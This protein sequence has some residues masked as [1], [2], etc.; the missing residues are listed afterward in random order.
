MFIENGYVW[1]A[2]GP[3]NASIKVQ[4]YTNKDCCWT[5]ET[6]CTLCT[7]LTLKAKSNGC[8][9][10]RCSC[11]HQSV[12]RLARWIHKV[13]RALLYH[14]SVLK[15]SSAHITDPCPCKP[16]L[17]SWLGESTPH[18]MLQFDTHVQKTPIKMEEENAYER[19]RAQRIKRNKE[20]MSQLQV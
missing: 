20:M 16:K 10:E 2:A 11:W 7:L 18:K 6:S 14:V 5:T 17:G 19:E 12:L 15:S 8:E 3:T 4:T 1:H 13:E 9:D